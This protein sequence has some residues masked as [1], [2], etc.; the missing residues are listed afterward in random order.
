MIDHDAIAARVRRDNTLGLNI[1]AAYLGLYDEVAK[2]RADL[3]HV[4]AERDA[5]FA[6]MLARTEKAEAERD[7]LRAALADARGLLVDAMVQLTDGK[8]KTRRNRALLIHDFL[9][10]DKEQPND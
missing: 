4:I 9:S 8:I 5:T 3:H 6:L 10:R 1:C 7:A 2:L